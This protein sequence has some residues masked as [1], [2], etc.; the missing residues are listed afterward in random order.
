MSSKYNI[1]L[2]DDDFIFLE[3]LKEVLIED[4][5][6]NISCFSTGEECIS[7][8]KYRPDIIILDYFLNSKKPD[9]ANGMQILKNIMKVNPET[10]VIILS[11]QEDGTLVFDFTSENAE[12][13]IIKDELAFEN[14]K[15]SIDE[16]IG[17]L[18]DETH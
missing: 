7:H 17:E 18:V 8:M 5:R 11:G 6:L 15:N 16:I 4:E 12:D 9:A 3:M 14:V 1:F 10:R 13:Y 2:V